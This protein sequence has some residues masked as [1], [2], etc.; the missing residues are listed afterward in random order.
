MLVDCHGVAQHECRNIVTCVDG[1][2]A[3]RIGV[4]ADQ[5]Q[6][7]AVQ[8]HSLLGRWLGMQVPPLR[9]THAALQQDSN[10]GVAGHYTTVA[11]WAAGVGRHG[12]KR[13]AN[14]LVEGCTALADLQTEGL[15]ELDRGGRIGPGTAGSCPNQ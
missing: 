10:R 8:T 1:S 5:A 2:A 6:L 15:V 3:D 11:L 7:K 9:E 12:F 4:E 13:N 14:I